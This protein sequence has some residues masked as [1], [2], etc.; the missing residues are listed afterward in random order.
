MLGR[1]LLIILGLLFAVWIA[2]II[3]FHNLDIHIDHE[4]DHIESLRKNSRDIMT[5][6][7]KQTNTINASSSSDDGQ[8]A[9]RF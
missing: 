9:N 1:F 8:S 3:N 7:E 5:L 2:V 6:S 4:M